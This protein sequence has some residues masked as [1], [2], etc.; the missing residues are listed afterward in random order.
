METSVGA[1]GE[2]DDPGRKVLDIDGVEIAIF[3]L[4]GK[5][6]AY[7]NVCPHLGGPACL[8]KILPLTHEDVEPDRTSNGRVF[9]K[10]DINVVCPW[11]GM[12]FDVRTG[13]HPIDSR[14]RLRRVKVRVDADRV[15]I[16]IPQKPLRA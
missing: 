13:A 16:T 12:E 14:F 4:G 10:T 6:Y 7:E 5:F 2:F 8:G 3:R 1:P 15:L 11:H 9:S